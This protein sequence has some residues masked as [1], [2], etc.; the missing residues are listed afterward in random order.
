LTRGRPHRR[1][2]PARLLVGLVV[3]SAGAI[4]ACVVATL[5][6]L[7]LVPPISA[8]LVFALP[9]IAGQILTGAQ[10]NRG[11]VFRSGRPF[12]FDLYSEL[13]VRDGLTALGLPTRH[14]RR[15]AQVL[16][17]API[18]AFVGFVLVVLALSA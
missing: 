16:W 8:L 9:L 17:V 13:V 11:D 15:V 2:A 3:L 5:A 12:I 1:P 6:G 7:G 4:C 14:S 18:A 10:L